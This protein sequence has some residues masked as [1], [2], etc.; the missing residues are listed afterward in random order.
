VPKPRDAKQQACAPSSL[1][2]AC[3]F[4]PVRQALYVLEISLKLV[5]LFLSYFFATIV[6]ACGDPS[7]EKFLPFAKVIKNGESK[8][9]KSFEVN[10]PTQERRF[11]LSDMTAIL[12]QQFQ[13]ELNHSDIKYYEG[14]YYTA[15]VTVNDKITENLEIVASYNALNKEVTSLVLCG[16]FKRYKLKQL[17]QAAIPEVRPMEPPK[18]II[19]K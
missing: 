14:N 1:I 4:A 12:P 18:P 6:F 10:F 3:Y 2:L 17:L 8:D 7:T 19:E 9:M 15:Y 13:I 11:F 16:N 5:A